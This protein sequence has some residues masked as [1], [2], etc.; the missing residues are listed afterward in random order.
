[1]ERHMA[2]HVRFVVLTGISPAAGADVSRVALR[3]PSG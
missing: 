1:M 3:A 2:A